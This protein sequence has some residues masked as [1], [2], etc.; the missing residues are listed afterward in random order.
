MMNGQNSGDVSIQ[1]SFANVNFPMESSIEE[2]KPVSKE[3][4]EFECRDKSK[5]IVLH[6]I[7]Q[8]SRIRRPETN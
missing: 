5:I 4:Y 6:G 7:Y 1:S 2:T 8:L 3:K